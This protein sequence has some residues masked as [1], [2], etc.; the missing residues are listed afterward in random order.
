MQLKLFKLIA[1][2]SIIS[3]LGSCMNKSDE[4]ITDRHV[5][6]NI[7]SLSIVEARYRTVNLLLSFYDVLTRDFG[8][9][10]WVPQSVQAQVEENF[11]IDC[12]IGY[13]SEAYRLASA[14][15]FTRQ[16]WQAAINKMHEIA[17]PYGFNAPKPDISEP[18]G[19]SAVFSH[20][21]GARIYISYLKRSIIQIETPCVKGKLYD[22][23][24]KGT[25]NIPQRLR[26][27]GR[28]EN[29]E[30]PETWATNNK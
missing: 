14:G 27:T 30:P 16:N 22:E 5:H 24:P 17:Q 19:A 15:P 20:P 28:Y 8:V 18:G 10:E 29:N 9:G 7:S 2:Y 21:K 4:Y 12:P 6:K 11:H 13:T 1:I 26:T 25:E 23:W 3:L